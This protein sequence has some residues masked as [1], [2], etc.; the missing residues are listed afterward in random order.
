M[1][2]N[3]WCATH[4]VMFPPA[5]ECPKC[6]DGEF[7]TPYTTRGEILDTAKALT[8][9]DRNVMYGPPKDEYT[10]LAILWGAFLEVPLT[11]QQTAVM[12]ALLKIN[13]TVNAPAHMD[14]YVDGAAYLAI[15]GE[16]A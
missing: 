14:S 15:A 8:E 13:R 2:H 16:C 7:V 12:M 1:K 11:A 10:R 4:Y 3:L 5:G 6:R 9:G